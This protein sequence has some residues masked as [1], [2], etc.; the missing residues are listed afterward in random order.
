MVKKNNVQLTILTILKM[1]N[2]VD[3]ATCTLCAADLYDFFTQN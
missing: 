1:Y 2:T 3:L